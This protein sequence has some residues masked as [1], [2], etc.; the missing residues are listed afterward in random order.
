MRS[1]A[2]PFMEEM[3]ASGRV[4]GSFGGSVLVFDIPGFTALTELFTQRGADGAEELS[5]QINGLLGS[6]VD[7]ICGSGG[8][9]GG[10]AGDSI[11]GVFPGRA[12]DFAA[13]VARRIHQAL[14]YPAGV[15]VGTAAKA[16]VCEG[17]IGWGIARSADRFLYYIRGRALHDATI[18]QA[19]CS[20]GA[21]MVAGGGGIT[22]RDRPPSAPP[23]AREKSF[24]VSE[25]V[26]ALDGTG[27]FRMVTSVFL[28][29]ELPQPTDP[30]PGLIQSVMSLSERMGGYLGCVEVKPAGLSLLVFFGAPVSHEDDAA[31]ADR[32]LREVFIGCSGRIR[33]G[34]ET[35]PVFAGLVG[36]ESHCTYTV[37]GSSVNLASRLMSRS[38]SG[39]ILAGPEF[40]ALT[41][42]RTVQTEEMKLRGI[43]RNSRVAV[44]SPYGRS[45]TSAFSAGPFV[46]RHEEIEALSRSADLAL[47]GAGGTAVLITAEA[48]M[49][50]TRLVREFLSTRSELRMLELECDGMVQRSLGPFSRFLGRQAGLS[51]NAGTDAAMAAFEEYLYRLAHSIPAARDGVNDGLKESLERAVQPL[52]SLLGLRWP[53]A[54]FDRLDPRARFENIR[55]SFLALFRALVLSG[56]NG[57]VFEDVQWIDGDSAALLGEL[58]ESMAGEPLLWIFTSRPESSTAEFPLPCRPPDL[59][60]R[61]G[62]L[63]PSEIERLVEMLL[64]SPPSKRLVEYVLSRS[65]GSPFFVEQYCGYLRE[66]G[67]TSSSNGGAD[68]RA[69]EPIPPAGMSSVLMARID[70]FDPEL[71]TAVQHAAVLGRQFETDVLAGMLGAVSVEDVIAR[72]TAESVWSPDRE[73]VYSFRHAMLRDAAYSMQL[74]SRL[75]ALHRKAAESIER[76][77]PGDGRFYADLAFHMEA[78]GD[79]P[80]AC[81]Y[82]EKAA[83]FSAGNFLI[84]ETVERYSR[85]IA[86]LDAGPARALARLRMAEFLTDCSRW[87]EAVEQ[88]GLA[89]E[90]PGRLEARLRARILVRLARILLERGEE[91]R[92][93][94]LLREASAQLDLEEDFSLRSMIASIE[95]LEMLKSDNVER[96][97]ELYRE[98]VDLARR[99]TDGEQLLRAIGSMGNYYLEVRDYHRAL[100]CYEEVRTGAIEAGNRN[101]EAIALGNIA[102]IRRAWMQFETA[103]ELLRN[104]ME[105]AV[106]TGN[107]LQLCMAMGNL[108]TVLASQ[109]GFEQSLQYYRQ[110]VEIAS[111]LKS[112]QHEA[113]ARINLAEH[114]RILG[115][116]DEALDNARK[117][118][119]IVREKA[120]THY[121]G[122]FLLI[123]ADTQCEIGDHDS[124]RASL[125]EARSL[126]AFGDPVLSDEMD[127]V[128]AKLKAAEDRGAATALLDGVIEAGRSRLHVSEAAFLRWRILG[129][130]ESLEKAQAACR[131]QI[132]RGDAPWRARLLLKRM[133][134]A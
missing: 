113:I 45:G 51:E 107:R 112:V 120:M 68:L 33:A 26:A 29:P 55:M 49:G 66:Q 15:E 115:F 19:S 83:A 24:F 3:A 77:H 111:E 6:A 59:T 7:I 38:V 71:R 133:E 30:L 67:H 92:G 95:A 10:F 74:R 8:F 44:L 88:L 103:E 97:A 5:G 84:A 21:T 28:S 4:S 101:L 79:I 73:A 90:E 40:S 131:A 94:R 42:L 20:P 98:C 134:G 23:A 13:S 75:R 82:L 81:E 104:Q 11:T 109:D 34:V 96:A 64:G 54:L 130:Q 2:P 18:A 69:G 124:A 102:I 65:E 61:L 91:A 89:L 106:E 56:S 129:S 72:G 16:G 35:G 57:I 85:L 123:L 76:R 25:R 62:P 128:E 32:F 46:G 117:A 52:G 118:V 100:E 41:A 1:F 60:M 14:R 126:L 116:L 43:S 121:L 36:N 132:E 110:A 58:R 114:C 39:R 17:E 122:S 63:S 50:K 99:G 12:A 127:I 125:A 22:G 48:G 70:R 9:V 86:L 108:G 78:A 87:D 80:G 53:G 93:F 119:Q 105:I 37:L 27:E 31:R 47:S